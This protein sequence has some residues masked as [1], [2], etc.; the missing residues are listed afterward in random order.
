MFEQNKK[1][2]FEIEEAGNKSFGML[3]SLIFFVVAIFILFMEYYIFPSILIFL[4]FLLFYISIF[5]DYALQ[6]YKIMWLR[7][8]FFLGKITTPIIMLFIFITLFVPTG[9][10]LFILRTDILDA[11]KSKA[12][13]TTWKPRNHRVETMDKQF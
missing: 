4:S 11:K 10:M 2:Y 5:R 7:L 9:I 6:T 1:S 8:G 3:F 12:R 13:K